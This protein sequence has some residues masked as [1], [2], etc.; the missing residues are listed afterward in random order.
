MG[1]ITLSEDERRF[2]YARRE[3]SC[4]AL[5]SVLYGSAFIAGSTRT[6]AQHGARVS[7]SGEYGADS[8][9]A[10]Q[11]LVTGYM[12][13]HRRG[14]AHGVLSALPCAHIAVLRRGRLEH[15]RLRDGAR[16][17]QLRAGLVGRARLACRR[18]GTGIFIPLMM[19]T[20]PWSRRRTKLART[21]PSA[22]A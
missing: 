16:R 2:L 3:T 11:G 21:C 14:H 20:I 9:T 1:P 15:R 19:N 18:W 17:S 4:A 7:I 12:T 22:A 5:L 8:Q 6:G 10:Q 13:R